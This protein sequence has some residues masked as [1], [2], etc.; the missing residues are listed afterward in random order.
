MNIMD[1]A[2]KENLL[3][4]WEFFAWMDNARWNDVTQL[5]EDQRMCNNFNEMWN[6]CGLDVNAA[7]LKPTDIVLAHW[8]TYIF[9]YGMPAETV[10]D[11]AFPI[12]GYIAIR[13]RK[14]ANWEEIIK[15]HVKQISPGGKR[16][17]EFYIKGP[18]GVHVFKHRFG[19]H[20]KLDEAVRNT[21]EG[22]EEKYQRDLV[23]FM[24]ENSKNSKTDKWVKNLAVELYALT[25]NR[26]TADKEELWHKRTWAAL[27]DYL[28]GN[29]HKNY[30]CNALTEYEGKYTDEVLEKWRK[31]QPYLDQLELP[32]DMWNIKFY[33]KIYSSYIGPLMPKS[34]KKMI[35]PKAIR[36]LYNDIL[37]KD[38][39][40]RELYPEQFDVT[41]DIAP[42]C[43]SKLCHICPLGLNSVNELCIGN[44]PNTQNKYCPLLASFCHYFVPC[45]AE[46]CPV[47][48]RR[49][50]SLCPQPFMA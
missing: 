8:L 5:K 18:R 49:T 22:L 10:W 26:N 34:H 47:L 25:Y 15:D 48:N 20:H 46:R 43:G 39:N 7:D 30:I 31:P 33:D 12:M 14:G 24:L 42:N 40:E 19:G 28:K 35:A 6:K 16:N 2:T 9:D 38:A 45:K 29:F 3:K 50:Q 32:G 27:R 44:L 21:L 23:I 36:V 1:I 4:L 41:F 37:N 13:Y 17:Y 11:N